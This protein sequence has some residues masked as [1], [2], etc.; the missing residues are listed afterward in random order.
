MHVKF[1]FRGISV[2]SSPENMGMSELED[3]ITP[4]SVN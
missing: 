1:K 3:K 2:T 4:G